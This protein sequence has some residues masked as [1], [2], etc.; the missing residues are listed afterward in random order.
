MRNVV[1]GALVGLLLMAGVR[2]VDA[3]YDSGFSTCGSTHDYGA[4]I[5]LGNCRSANGL[6]YFGG[7]SEAEYDLQTDCDM[8]A[9]PYIGELIDVSGHWEN[10]TYYVVDSARCW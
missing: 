1:T 3:Y 5:Q 4:Y 6:G 10:D 2:S 9:Y 7:E 8:W